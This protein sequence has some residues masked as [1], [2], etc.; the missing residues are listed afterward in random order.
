MSS[1]KKAPRARARPAPSAAAPSTVLAEELAAMRVEI[2]SLKTRPQIAAA[3]TPTARTIAASHQPQKS[4]LSSVLSAAAKK[5]MK[6]LKEQGMETL[7]TL[8]TALLSSDRIKCQ[9]GVTDTVLPAGTVLGWV[10]L[11]PN[12]ADQLAPGTHTRLSRVA[13]T[14]MRWRFAG[15]TCVNFVPAAGALTNGQ[16][17]MFITSDPRYDLVATG[18]AAVRLVH[19]FN[20]AVCQISQGMC[21]NVP[22]KMGDWLYVEDAHESDV[23]FTRQGTLWVIAFTDIDITS[24]GSSLGE[25]RL[26]YECELKDNSI[27]GVSI[28]PTALPDLAYYLGPSSTCT[29][30][31]PSSFTSVNLGLF[32]SAVSGAPQGLFYGATGY[33]VASAGQVYLNDP[34][35]DYTFQQ[36]SAGL[37]FMFGT[38]GLY[39]IKAQADFNYAVSATGATITTGD[40]ATAHISWFDYNLTAGVMTNVQTQAL[41]PERFH[42]TGSGYTFYGSTPLMLD[43]YLNTV[44]SGENHTIGGLLTLTYGTFSTS[45]YPVINVSSQNSLTITLVAPASANPA[46]SLDRGFLKAPPTNGSA[47]SSP[48]ICGK[49]KPQ[50]KSIEVDLSETPTPPRGPLTVN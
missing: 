5:A 11:Y 25:F 10:D 36:N 43:Y 38:P 15:K 37:A 42:N 9:P 32:G 6:Y 18:Q 2:A 24:A 39:H 49:V 50:A 34:V 12:F 16:I 47:T 46:V 21:L 28:L 41:V 1:S 26:D 20:G 23:R 22:P 8:G 4:S 13:S 40:T 14:F 30:I 29:L 17:G 44:T 33:S 27:D 3:K 7:F 45:T 35:A 19:E 48:A 31:V